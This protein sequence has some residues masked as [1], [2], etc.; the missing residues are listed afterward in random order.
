MKKILKKA[1]VAALAAI[2]TF[3][4]IGVTADTGT[5]ATDVTVEKAIALAKLLLPIPDDLT[6]FE[7]DKWENNNGEQSYYLT[8]R[9]EDNT[10]EA[11]VQVN[12]YGTIVYY[13]FYDSNSSSKGLSGYTRSELW[14]RA[15]EFLKNAVPDQAE[16]LVLS[17]EDSTAQRAEFNRYENG[18]R[19]EDNGASVGINAITGEI[20]YFSLHW[21]FESEFPAEEPAITSD[22]GL[23]A[24]SGGAV[25]LEYDTFRN[26]ETATVFSVYAADA[27]RG[28]SEQR[29]IY[30]AFPVYAADTS[31]R[32][33]AADGTLFKA[34][35]PESFSADASSASADL[36]AGESGSAGGGDQ[37][38]KLTQEELAAVE[39]M[40][41]L[42]TK[43]QAKEKLSSLT[44]LWLPDSYSLSAGYF[45]VKDGDKTSYRLNLKYTTEDDG[46]GSVYMDAESGEITSVAIY[47]DGMYKAPQN[48]VSDE[49]CDA[50]AVSFIEKIKDIS[51]YRSY[52]DRAD[53]ASDSNY[54]YTKQYVRYIGEIPY[55]DDYKTAKV[56][57]SS[58]KVYSYSEYSPDAEII[59][60]EALTD[61]L[62]A[63]KANYEA[64]LVYTY[65]EG[66]VALAYALSPLSDLSE[67]KA[68]TG[69][70]IGYNGEIVK[71]RGE[72]ADESGHWAWEIF[73]IMRENNI[74]ID[75]AYSLDDK[76]NR[77]DF[78]TLARMGIRRGDL[79]FSW[80]Y[81]ESDGSET[82]TREAAAKTLMRL[83][84]W[85]RLI[86]LDV[87]K[88]DFADEADFEGGVGGAA[89]LEGLGI[90]TGEN[91]RY[92]PLRELT[93]GEAYVIAYR[94][95]TA[96]DG[97]DG[98]DSA[99]PAVYTAE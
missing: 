71:S 23:A 44:E 80:Y 51:E 14:Q 70:A 28:L 75:G 81:D 89:V 41:S 76:I 48:P 37:N 34:S 91:G 86:D 47:R 66:V 32:A 88:T 87:F 17:E 24:L 33:S 16:S 69:E 42:I 52:S 55:P 90:L 35:Q 58:G 31:Y 6:E 50:V 26:D 54:N 15:D 1:A 84:G 36:A 53:F 74:Y 99:T 46:T 43:E 12:K 85:E 40:Q 8:W 82:V 39:A 27:M 60:P 21:D 38:Y 67:I 20:T 13:W 30:T 64:E 49:D 25:R 5:A 57:K 11:E 83:M 96:V 97:D 94:L 7:Y 63:V 45:T 68:E 77:N 18:V 29:G 92:Y 59:I 95:A 78:M 73:N 22:E 65:N 10:R 93:Y 72:K 98:D 56:S 4:A 62:E 79:P 3:A 9:N 61:K 19:V 2:M